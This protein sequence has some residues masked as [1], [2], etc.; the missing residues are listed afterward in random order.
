MTSKFQQS[1][2]QSQPQHSPNLKLPQS[3]KAETYKQQH[4]QSRF[5]P[6]RTK[7]KIIRNVNR[8]SS[9]TTEYVYT[10]NDTDESVLN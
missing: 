9:G 3:N 7:Q 10:H 4:L 1:Y 6:E 5:I 8:M 2:S